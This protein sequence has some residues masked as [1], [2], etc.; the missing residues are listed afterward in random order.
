MAKDRQQYLLNQMGQSLGYNNL[1]VLK[2]L[3]KF[4]GLVLFSLKFRFLFL[5]RELQSNYSLN[6]TII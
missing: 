5:E 3:V 2:R 1:F 4:D 6:I